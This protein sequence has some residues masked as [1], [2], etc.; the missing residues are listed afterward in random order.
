M[1]SKER[2]L[3][4]AGKNEAFYQS[5]DL[6]STAF[7]DWAVTGLFY[8][9]LHYVDAF[10]ATRG[11]SSGIDPDNHYQREFWLSREI[12]L[13]SIYSNYQELKNRSEDARYRLLHFTPMSVAQLEAT[14]L[15]PIRHTIQA[16]L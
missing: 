12:L 16:H 3:A 7:L 4:Q 14:H 8:A 13:T 10:L 9:A 5:F 1:P 11:T 6:P 15:G 2:H